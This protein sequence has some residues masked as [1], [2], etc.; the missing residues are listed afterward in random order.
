MLKSIFDNSS[1][2]LTDKLLFSRLFVKL[3]LA[4]SFLRSSNEVPTLL[5]KLLKVT[6]VVRPEL[7]TRLAYVALLEI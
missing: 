1:T 2:S 3:Y 4:I 6:V 5:T 7:E